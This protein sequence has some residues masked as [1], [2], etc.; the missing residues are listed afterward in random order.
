MF[1]GLLVVVI[2]FVASLGMAEVTSAVVKKVIDG[3]STLCVEGGD[4]GKFAFLLT[5]VTAKQVPGGLQLAFNRE[6][7]V[8][9]K[10][11]WK[12]ISAD[13]YSNYRVLGVDGKV[14]AF[15]R[16]NLEMVVVA[17]EEVLAKVISIDGLK[18]K[19][20]AIDIR[21]EGLFTEEQND[22]LKNGG[23]TVLALDVFE[24]GTTIITPE[25][26]ESAATAMRTSSGISRIFVEI[27]K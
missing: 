22:E 13:H 11:G 10:Q 15:K 8:C 23:K 21:T 2:T 16:T 25:D 5:D 7:F 19:N 17:R 3:K 6:N 27:K 20:V 12:N 18:D 24:R 4:L 1:K 14:Y 9:T 26:G